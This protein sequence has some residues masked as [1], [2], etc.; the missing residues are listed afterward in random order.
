MET[1]ISNIAFIWNAQKD[2]SLGAGPI[3]LFGLLLIG[4]ITMVVT[5]IYL[6][7]RR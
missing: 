6:E 7:T 5:A 3:W 2:W 4:G 1:V